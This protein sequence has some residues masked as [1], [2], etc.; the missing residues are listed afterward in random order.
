MFK[1]L[2]S[3]FLSAL[4][5]LL[6]VLFVVVVVAATFRTSPNNS[7][8][9]WCGNSEETNET[10]KM[11]YFTEAWC[12]CC[13]SLDEYISCFFGRF[14]STSTL[15]ST[16]LML[17]LSSSGFSAHKTEWLQFAKRLQSL[18]Y[19]VYIQFYAVKRCLINYTWLWLWLFRFS[20]D[21]KLQL[22]LRIHI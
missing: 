9:Q 14:F 11:T 7:H 17:S 22:Q 10:A 21:F 5:L 2:M 13:Y 20:F 1:C 6:L 15:T 19:F 3:M 8:A 12:R 4:L 18:V 16:S